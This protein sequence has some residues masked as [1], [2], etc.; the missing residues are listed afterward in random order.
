MLAAIMLV[1][2]YGRYL[3]KR[4]DEYEALLVFL[5]GLERHISV[6]VGAPD[7]YLSA[8]K[9][10]LL[11]ELGFYGAYASG[12]SLSAAYSAVREGLHISPEADRLLLGYFGAFGGGYFNAE[13]RSLGACISSLRDI[14]EKE[15]EEG[16]RSLRVSSV[17]AVAV[18]LGIVIMLV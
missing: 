9:V 12:G 14:A 8:V 15:G 5:T 4:G 18:A 7:G 6:T 17:F 11:D 3:R 10:K 13:L 16:A 1:R 2:G